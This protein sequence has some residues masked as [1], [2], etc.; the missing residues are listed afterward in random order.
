MMEKRQFCRT[1]LTMPVKVRHGARVAWQSV[2]NIS[3]GGAY[4]RGK[5]MARRGER[6]ELVF[7]FPG[8]AA[9]IPLPCRVVRRDA[10]GI[11]VHFIPYPVGE[12]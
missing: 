3:R 10:A 6:L 5:A 2:E 9:P 12:S 7:S 4:I 8:L 11:G 1:D